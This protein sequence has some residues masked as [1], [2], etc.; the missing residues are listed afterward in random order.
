M[1]IVA[2]YRPNDRPILLFASVSWSYFIQCFWNINDFRAGAEFSNSYASGLQLSELILPD[3]LG[4]NGC[5]RKLVSIDCGVNFPASSIRKTVLVGF[6]GI[7]GR[8]Y[9]LHC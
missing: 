5:R 9:M 1:I 3:Y 4:S 8:K 6:V 2:H 7:A